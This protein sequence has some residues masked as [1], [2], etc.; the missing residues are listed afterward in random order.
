MSS[1]WQFFD[2]QMAI[3]Q[4][5]RCRVQTYIMGSNFDQFIQTLE[6]GDCEKTPHV[7]HSNKHLD[8]PQLVLFDTLLKNL[9]QISILE[10][11]KTSI[12]KIQKLN[13]L[14]RF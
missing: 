13:I 3:F 7:N 11:I 5:V 1:F 6:P 2:T 8:K 10:K 4:R 12:L 9:N 14:S